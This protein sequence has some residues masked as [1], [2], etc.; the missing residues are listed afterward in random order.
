MNQMTL[1]KLIKF[2]LVKLFRKKETILFGAMFLIPLLYSV[3]IMMKSS[4]I[5]YNGTGKVNALKFAQEMYIFVYMLFIFF[6]VTAYS[7]AATLKG[8]IENRSIKILVNRVGNRKLIYRSKFIAHWLFHVIITTSFTVFAI[9]CFYLFLRNSEFATNQLYV[10]NQ[11]IENMMRLLSIHLL[12][13]LAISMGMCLSTYFKTFQSV[14]I[15]LVIWIVFAYFKSFDIVKYISPLY[16]TENIINQSQNS[17]VTHILLLIGYSM[18]INLIL[19][20]IGERKFS[21]YDI[22]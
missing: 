14:G 7:I 5:T 15:F 2:E 1:M 21:K 9:L 18:L 4:N 3:G 22:Q 12:F 10:G 13:V 6:I 8:E 20:K 19:W 16:Y 11:I 17:T